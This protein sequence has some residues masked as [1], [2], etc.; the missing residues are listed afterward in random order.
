MYMQLAESS[1]NVLFIG[2]YE[3]VS[4]MIIFYYNIGEVPTKK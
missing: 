3:C 2:T 4:Y 1:E